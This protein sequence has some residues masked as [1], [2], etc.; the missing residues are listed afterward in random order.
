MGSNP[1]GSVSRELCEGGFRG[2]GNPCSYTCFTKAFT[3]PSP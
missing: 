1:P 3:V 2:G